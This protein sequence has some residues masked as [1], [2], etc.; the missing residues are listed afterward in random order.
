MKIN[1]SILLILFA[2]SG[3]A[4]TNKLVWLPDSSVATTLLPDPTEPQSMI[5]ITSLSH[6]TVIDYPM[7]VP[8]SFGFRK[9]IVR[10]G[11][12][13]LGI[14]CSGTTEFG[15]RKENN[16]Y[17]H[18][19]RKSL[20]N[21]DYQLG[22][23][24]TRLLDSRSQ[25][26]IRFFHRSS[27]LGDDYLLLNN[28]KSTGYWINDPSNFEQINASYI[29]K[30]KKLTAYTTLGYVAS[31]PINR[32]PLMIQAGAFA[33]DFRQK[34]INR[35]VV[36]FDFRSLENNNFNPNLK[37]MAGIKIKTKKPMY[38][39]LEYYTGHIPYSRYESNLI[40]QWIGV[41]LYLDSVL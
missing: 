5:S 28:I 23:T 27:H 1:V 25:I 13:E 41:G 14:D 9:A 11:K 33:S 35:L 6:N 19:F 31:N 16:K 39:V 4:Q 10:S 22:L 34:I 29:R 38:A 3:I 30:I 20:L 17:M 18:G 21:I 37:F 24:Y 15:W 12:N 7:Y 40:I 26:K 2:F 32:K 8:F 36:G